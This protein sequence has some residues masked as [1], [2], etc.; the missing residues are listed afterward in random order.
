MLESW[1]SSPL[2]QVRRRR[3]SGSG[4][5]SGVVIHGP[6]GQNVA[7]PFARVHCG[8]RRL[9]VAGADVVGHGEAGQGPV[10]ADHHDQLA[11]VVEPPHDGGQRTGPPGGATA[12]GTF[13]NTIG[14]SGGAAPVSAAWAA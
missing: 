12:V 14:C 3:S 1:R 5:S 13:V 7:A 2:T 6:H 10:G 11:L 8:S 9:E 4:T